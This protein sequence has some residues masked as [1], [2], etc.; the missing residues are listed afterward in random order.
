MP[1]YKVSDTLIWSSE[2][3]RLFSQWAADLLLYL[4]LNYSNCNSEIKVLTVVGGLM[5]SLYRS[6]HIMR[7][8]LVWETDDKQL[9]A[10]FIWCAH[11]IKLKFYCGYLK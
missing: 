10:I 6:L 4:D 3:S 7:D 9:S 1:R 5:V 8:A 11:I 2:N